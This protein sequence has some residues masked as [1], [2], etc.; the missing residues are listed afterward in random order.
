MLQTY[1]LGRLHPISTKALRGK[2]SCA[3]GLAEDGIISLTVRFVQSATRLGEPNWLGL[4]DK[5]SQLA[6]VFTPIFPLNSTL[7]FFWVA[8]C[9]QYNS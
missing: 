3:E 8:G 1:V 9:N 2:Y 7:Q 6:E 5:S 4:L